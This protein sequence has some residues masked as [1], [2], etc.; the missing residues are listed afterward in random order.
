MLIVKNQPANEADARNTSLNPGSGSSSGAGNGY[1][2]QY[3]CLENSKDRG[4][5][6]A[7]D[8]GVAEL[9]MTEHAHKYAITIPLA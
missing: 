1:S 4:A 2:H 7:T 6:Q 3:S 9:D 5:W 8:H